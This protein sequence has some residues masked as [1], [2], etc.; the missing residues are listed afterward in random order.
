VGQKRGKGN[1]M[2]KLPLC[3]ANSSTL[4][5]S[6]TKVLAGQWLLPSVIGTM[7]ASSQNH[8]VL[9]AIVKPISIDMVDTLIRLK[10]PTIGLFPDKAVLR[11]PTISLATGM[12][13]EP[14]HTIAT[15]DSAHLMRTGFLSRQSR[16]VSRNEPPLLAP[17]QVGCSATA[18]S[19]SERLWPSVSKMMSCCYMGWSQVVAVDVLR[20][21]VFVLRTIGDRLVTATRTNCRRLWGIGYT[22]LKS[23]NSRPEMMEAKKTWRLVFMPSFLRDRLAAT[24]FANTHS[25][26]IPQRLEVE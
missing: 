7:D 6:A 14:E 11:D 20:H 16:S 25:W 21:A 17:T 8:E 26:I 23:L 18:T 19:T 4:L 24:T 5:A 2:K 9:R 13:G 12:V 22:S 3:P 10:A 1:S 15:I